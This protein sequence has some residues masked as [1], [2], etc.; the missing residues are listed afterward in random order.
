MDHEMKFENLATLK[1]FSAITSGFVLFI[2]A[3][4]AGS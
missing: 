1:I 3:Y 4:F 2:N